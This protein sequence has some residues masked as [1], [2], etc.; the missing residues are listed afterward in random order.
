VRKE[1]ARE[2]CRAWPLRPAAS[3]QPAAA[4]VASALRVIGAIAIVRELGDA[5]TTVTGTGPGQ[6]HFSR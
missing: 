2:R 5:L 4:I 1:R 3:I 6:D